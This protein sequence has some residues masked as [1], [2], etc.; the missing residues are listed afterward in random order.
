LKELLSIQKEVQTD[1][2]HVTLITNQELIA[3][4]VTWNRDL[5]FNFHVGDIYKSVYNKDISTNNI[6]SLD[7]TERRILKDICKD[8]VSYY[9]LIDN[10]I[11]LQET[12]TLMISKYGLHNDVENRIGKFVK[13]Y[14]K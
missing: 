5:I 2:P 4:Q 6:K 1:R 10:L 3:I 14:E 12:K 8:D 13:D 9:H 7:E 11:T